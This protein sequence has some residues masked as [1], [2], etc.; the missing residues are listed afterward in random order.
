MKEEASTFRVMDNDGNT[1]N[2]VRAAEKEAPS[3]SFETRVQKRRD[4]AIRKCQRWQ[5]T[6]YRTE[7]LKVV[8]C[9][10]MGHPI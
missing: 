6:V 7:T 3:D 1:L 10:S 2:F 9:D 5:L 8:P 4:E